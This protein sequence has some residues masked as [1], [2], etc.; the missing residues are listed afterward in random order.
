M[1]Q[2]S[3][4]SLITCNICGGKGL[5]EETVDHLTWCPSNR[6]YLEEG[7]DEEQADKEDE[8]EEEH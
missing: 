5:S 2:T 3:T 1:S 8:Q 4:P 6:T 7:W